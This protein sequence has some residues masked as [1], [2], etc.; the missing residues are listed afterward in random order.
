MFLKNEIVYNAGNIDDKFYIVYNGS[1]KLQKLKVK[2]KPET[3]CEVGNTLMRLNKKDITGVE[4][5]S[6]EA[7]RCT[8][9]VI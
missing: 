1:F 8:L 3:I 9:Q 2:A 4:A 5:C 7:Y 6:G